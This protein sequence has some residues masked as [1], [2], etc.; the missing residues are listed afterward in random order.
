MTCKSKPT[1]S[2][3]SKPTDSEPQP[4]ERERPERSERVPF[5]VPRQRIIRPTGC[6]NDGFQYRVF[7]DNWANDPGRI[8]RAKQA[9]Y[10][11]VDNFEPLPVGS[12][13]DGSPIK[14][15]LMRIPQE[16]YDEDQK[17]KQKTV[18]AVDAAIKAG[19]L[20]QSASDKRY[21]PDGIKVWGS[22]DENR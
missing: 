5:G 2:E 3:K 14:G 15:V 8:Q 12:N 7:N 19:T 10:E 1:D 6:E 18:D 11:V 20:E 21:I 17:L 22:H 9:G 16:W 4:R 13:D